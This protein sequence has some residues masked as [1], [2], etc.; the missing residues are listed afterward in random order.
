MN[1]DHAVFMAVLTIPKKSSRASKVLQYMRKSAV[2][3][4]RLAA[5]V[6]QA[7]PSRDQF[8]IGKIDKMIYSEPKIR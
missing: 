7:A 1:H 6:A 4:S 8:I 2:I 5:T 3:S